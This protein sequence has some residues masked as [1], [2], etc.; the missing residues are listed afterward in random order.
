MHLFDYM[1]EYFLQYT[2]MFLSFVGL[3]KTNFLTEI[4][5]EIIPDQAIT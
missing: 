5:L 4:Y 2:T 1:P 3:F